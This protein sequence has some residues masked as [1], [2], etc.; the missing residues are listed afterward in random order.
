MVGLPEL[1]Y[2]A[3]AASLLAYLVGWPAGA[4]GPAQ[5]ARWRFVA[6]GIVAGF[7]V[8][9]L[10]GWPLPTAAFVGCVGGML[11]VGLGE[12]AAGRPRMA[13]DMAASAGSSG[14]DRVS[15]P[16]AASAAAPIPVDPFPIPETAPAAGEPPSNHAIATP[17]TPAPVPEEPLG[18]ELYDER[19]R[20]SDRITAPDVLVHGCLRCATEN[21]AD[22]RFCKACSAPLVPWT[23]EGCGRVNSVDA[24]FCDGCGQPVP[25]LVSPFEVQAI[26]ED[27]PEAP[28]ANTAEAASAV[29]LVDDVAGRD[30]LSADDAQVIDVTGE[31]LA[32]PTPGTDEEDPTDPGIPDLSLPPAIS[33]TVPRGPSAAAAEPDPPAADSPA[34]A[35]VDDASDEETGSR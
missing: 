9:A 2:G 5:G 32:H 23:C 34:G 11:A 4:L 30:V 10:V 26:P 7:V 28:A 18:A 24:T 17:G 25:L 15:F 8:L 16:A 3:C 31:D 33:G 6:A 22:A 12:A 29:P 21:A 1:A 35:A 20:T 14:P 13:P 19:S 27:A